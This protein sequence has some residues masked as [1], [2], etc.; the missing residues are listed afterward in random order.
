MTVRTN[1]VHGGGLV[2]VHTEGVLRVVGL[3]SSI[4]Y[5]KLVVLCMFY[6]EFPFDFLECSLT[7]QSRSNFIV[8]VCLYVRFF[9]FSVNS[10]PTVFCFSSILV[11]VHT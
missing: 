6:C 4:I 3:T 5:V 10:R 7:L 1:L 11:F 9:Y 2:F 8:F